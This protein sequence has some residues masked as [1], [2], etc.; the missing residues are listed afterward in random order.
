MDAVT[1][2][3]HT[4]ASVYPRTPHSPPAKEILP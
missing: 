3:S 1:R 2:R 4:L